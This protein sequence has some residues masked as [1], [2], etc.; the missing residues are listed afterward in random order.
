MHPKFIK[1][2]EKQNYD[3]DIDYNLEHVVNYKDIGRIWMIKHIH[4]ICYSTQSN[5]FYIWEEV[6]IYSIL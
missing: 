4:D 1:W 3:W 6:L 5:K 2:L